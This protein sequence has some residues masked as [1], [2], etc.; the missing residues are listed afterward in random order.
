MIASITRNARA[1]PTSGE[2]TIGMTTLSTIVFQCTTT[3]R[4]GDAAP[5]RPPMRACDDDEGS[6]KYHVIRFQ[7]IAPSSPASTMTSP[8]CPVAAMIM[9]LDRVRDLLAEQRADEVH[10]RGHRERD[11]RGQRPRRDR[12]GDRVGGVVEPVGV[13]EARGRRRRPR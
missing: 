7:V 4:R 8:A 1:K 9:S 2:T 12:G 10:H 6:P 5:T 11:P 13:V 3:V